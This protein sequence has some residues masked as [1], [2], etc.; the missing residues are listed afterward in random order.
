MFPSICVYNKSSLQ[1][2]ARDSKW[3][4]EQEPLGSFLH[5]VP[6]AIFFYFQSDGLDSK[7]TCTLVR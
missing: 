5:Q 2:P 7:T 6:E 3:N 4:Q 1:C